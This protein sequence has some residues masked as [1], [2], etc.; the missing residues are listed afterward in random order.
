MLNNKII[1]KKLKKRTNILNINSP[2]LNLIIMKRN[3]FF[4]LMMFAVV[5][6]IWTGCAS[7]KTSKTAAPNYIGT[8]NYVLETPEGE[9]EGALVFT[10]EGDV[11]TGTIGSDAGSQALEKLVISEEKVS[12]LFDFQGYEINMTGSF[13]ENI[14]DGLMSVSGYDIPFKATKQ[15]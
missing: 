5:L 6:F 7:T 1:L 3:N 9:Q 12:A 15:E 14:L 4:M 2:F 10:Q 8:W 13:A 11:V